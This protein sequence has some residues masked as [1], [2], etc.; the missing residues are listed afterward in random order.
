[1]DKPHRPD[2]PA[3]GPPKFGRDGKKMAEDR[4]FAGREAT[5]GA[6]SLVSSAPLAD[7][8][9]AESG[10]GPR[11]TPRITQGGG[12]RL[13]SAERNCV[14]MLYERAWFDGRNNRLWLL[15]VRLLS[16]STVSFV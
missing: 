7:E 9:R 1:M 14:V 8:W 12:G 10:V 2:Q 6:S 5:D 13:R 15:K 3:R 11:G 4:R 16:V